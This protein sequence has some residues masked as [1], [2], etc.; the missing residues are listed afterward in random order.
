VLLNNSKHIPAT[1]GKIMQYGYR[2]RLKAEVDDIWWAVSSI[3]GQTGYYYADGL[4]RLRGL[5][6]RC[7]GGVGLRLGRRHPT[8]LRVGDTLDFWRVLDVSPKKRLLLLAE[9]KFPGEALLDFKIDSMGAHHTDLQMLS[10][11]LPKG[12]GG[13]LYWYIFYPFHEWIFFGM[14]RGIAKAVEKPIVSGPERF[15]PKRHGSCVFPSES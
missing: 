6:D 7:F 8:E 10:C 4:W 14:L 12:L 2:V 1:A 13:I 3:G 9:M 5:M 11:Y 15:T